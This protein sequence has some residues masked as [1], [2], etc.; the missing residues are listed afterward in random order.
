M[1]LLRLELAGFKSFCDKAVVN[2][3]QDGISVI[4]GP[5]GC[6]KS[7]IVDAIRWALGEQ[8]AKHLRGQNMEDVIFGGS[9]SRAPVGM[10]QVSLTFSNPS[11]ESDHKYAQFSE[12]TITRRLYR[13]GESKY[14]INKTPC[15]LADIRELFMDTGI[16]GR[17]YSIIEQGKIDKVITSKPED[18][19]EII[20]E[21]AGIVKFKTK[22]K[23]AERKFGQTKQNLLRIDDVL[24]E[25]VRQE[26]VLRD[27]VVQ[28]EKFVNA[29]A[30]LIR[31]RQCMD[32]FKWQRVKNRAD[33]LL[34]SKEEMKQQHFD[35]NNK[36]AT[37]KAE[38]ASLQVDISL[39][40][41]DLE[42]KREGAQSLKETIIK[43]ESRLENDTAAL[44]NLSEW[45]EKGKEE[46]EQLGKKLDETEQLLSDY[47][48]DVQTLD[49]EIEIKQ[50]FLDRLQE[51]EKVHNRRFLELKEQMSEIREKE[52]TVKTRISGQ[53]NRMYQLQERL[54]E[55]GERDAD[56]LEKEKQLSQNQGDI[57]QEVNA[58][59]AVYE[60]LVEE[61]D[62][63]KEAIDSRL[64]QI[65]DLEESISG[66]RKQQTGLSGELLKLNSRSASLTELLEHHEDCDSSVKTFLE[67]LDAHPE[68]KKKLG[69]CGVLADFVDS[70]SEMSIQDTTFLNRY[71]NLLIFSSAISLQAIRE[72]ITELDLNTVEVY[73]LDLIPGENSVSVPTSSLVSLTD[74]PL[75]QLY[76]QNEE[77]LSEAGNSVLSRT[78]GM[79]DAKAG[80]MTGEKVFVLG[81]SGNNAASVYLKRKKDLME[82][83]KR[84]EEI[85]GQLETIENNLDDLLEQQ[86]ELKRM[87][88]R[89][90]KEAQEKQMELVRLEKDIESLKERL[91][92]LQQGKDQLE[93]EK[94]R[95]L[96]NRT[97]FR[98]EIL[99]IEKQ[100]ETDQEQSIEIQ[101]K[102]KNLEYQ[103]ES[104]Q[105]EH[106]ETSEE[107]QHAR[108][109]KAGL[110]EKR[111]NLKNSIARLRSDKKQMVEQIDLIQSRSDET[112]Q[113]RE[114]LLKAIE[115]TKSR[116]P[117]LLEELSIRERQ[118]REI[119]DQIEVL[120][121]KVA[122][123]SKLVR[124][125][126]KSAGK[127]SEQSHKI[128]IKL[129]QLAQEAEDIKSRLFAEHSVNPEDILQTFEPEEFNPKNEEETIR[130]LQKTV[131]TMGNV[132]LAAKEEYDALK[133]RLD[134]IQTQSDDLNKSIEALENSI[135][136]INMESRKRFKETFTAVNE[137]FGKLF[138]Q[139][140]G[141]GEAHL[142]LNDE[143]DL[144]T[145]GVEII[146]QPP[147]KKL[148][149]MT[150]LSGGEKALTA[151]AL[152]FAIFQIKPSPFCLLDEVDA[153]L[154]DAN[155]GRF[156]KHVQL[157]T[158]N[159]QFIVIT[160]NK[161]TM[162]I[163]N[164]LFGV[165]MEEP[166][167][168]KIVSVNFD[169]LEN[170]IAS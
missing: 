98:E 60:S 85:T 168:S 163:G 142:K 140:F 107:A 164:A 87:L 58:R 129:A 14:M 70:G 108:I 135:A 47:D 89:Q 100:V 37:L 96:E 56:F 151:I 82:I 50:E 91:Q 114:V 78:F 54:S 69:F 93:K 154:D 118:L 18:R 77:P 136:K 95:S 59:T 162:E 102:F 126:Q 105:I 90:Q 148:Q 72:V 34:D 101:K 131:D 28:A 13:S 15:R 55:E 29:R 145:T 153:P 143:S 124:E 42:E 127:T 125:E 39:K 128:D 22:K 71:F 11:S 169:K 52:M 27:Q 80:L 110:E 103:F 132:N 157:M 26:E 167:T 17:A 116:L 106:E 4:V 67:Y 97:R 112:E 41:T 31:L 51:E 61:N 104:A 88:N 123:I 23:E 165:T 68:L 62:I 150:L 134:F 144:L 35:I 66:Y 76:Q 32:A 73:F 64:E 19:R 57:E 83:T 3:V 141:G 152:I 170:E 161:K 45:K 113:K 63:E 139:L 30:R 111:T 40:T 53:Q 43:T 7:N 133:E 46:A 115:E 1:R 122:E 24:A 109:V 160:H 86:D 25:L 156:N 138:P 119:S 9:S 2:F 146:A 8:S 99:E 21:A 158:E 147:G 92:F 121:E 149:N 155:A 84:Q 33:E 6:G 49:R 16:G 38:E 12:I 94:Q 36:L 81:K 120:R 5:N 79:I 10:A 75:Y 117:D 159:S 130:R 44:H 48:E 166:G 74:F 65:S 20:D 137:R